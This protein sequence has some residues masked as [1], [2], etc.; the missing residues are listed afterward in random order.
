MTPRAEERANLLPKPPR[1]DLEAMGQIGRVL[2][3]V[4]GDYPQP[5]IPEDLGLAD[6]EPAHINTKL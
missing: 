6:V 4:R 5:I 1:T 2:L 3:G